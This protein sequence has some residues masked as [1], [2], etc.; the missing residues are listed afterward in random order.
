MRIPE[1]NKAGETIW[2]VLDIKRE[3][4]FHKIFVL[5]IQMNNSSRFLGVGISDERQGV[6]SAFFASGRVGLKVV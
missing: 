2:K 4:I 1:R 3:Q 5:N 6:G